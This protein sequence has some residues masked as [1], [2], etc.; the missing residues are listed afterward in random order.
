MEALNTSR[1]ILNKTVL[2]DEEVGIRTLHTFEEKLG[3]F[4]LIWMR[5]AKRASEAA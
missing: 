3:K 2:W 5:V 4:R 1:I